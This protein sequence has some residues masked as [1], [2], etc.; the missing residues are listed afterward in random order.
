MAISYTHVLWGRLFQ[1][2]RRPIRLIDIA[3]E[4][5]YDSQQK[6]KKKQICLFQLSVKLSQKELDL[7]Q[8]L[9]EY[10]KIWSNYW[11]FLRSLFIQDIF[12]KL[13]LPFFRI[14]M[15]NELQ[16]NRHTFWRIFPCEKA[17]RW[18]CDT[19]KK[20]QLKTPWIYIFRS[21]LLEQ[22]VVS[23]L[24]PQKYW[25]CMRLQILLSDSQAA[26]RQ[27]FHFPH[28]RDGSPTCF[29]FL[30][31]YFHFEGSSPFISASIKWLSDAITR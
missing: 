4:E 15:K 16:P 29:L 22:I 20:K 14:E 19:E 8:H 31:E 13:I 10:R 18:L 6:I 5:Q 1:L 27:M 30:C 3:A 25:C 7:I 26:R 28:F 24:L 12:F 23:Q 9:S 17:L 2:V 21:S 11:M